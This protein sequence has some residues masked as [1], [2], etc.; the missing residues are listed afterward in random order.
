[1]LHGLYGV[2]CEDLSTRTI[3]IDS[4]SSSWRTYVPPPVAG[5]AVFSS[6]FKGNSMN[7]RKN[8]RKEKLEM[9]GWP[10]CLHREACFT[11][12]GRRSRNTCLRMEVAPAS[13]SAYA[14]TSTQGLATWLL[15][16]WTLH[17]GRQE[18]VTSSPWLFAVYKGLYYPV[19]YSNYY[20]PHPS[21]S[22]ME[23]K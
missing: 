6:S 14:E 10:V 1:M 19:Q 11:T 15:C 20:G 2:E 17:W 18:S 5:R 3:W 16:F 8:S 13:A 22:K 7:L 9:G 21:T 23:S 12:W 4:W